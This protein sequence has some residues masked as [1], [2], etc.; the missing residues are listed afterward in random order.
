MEYSKSYLSSSQRFGIFFIA[1]SAILAAPLSI[2]A[3]LTGDSVALLLIDNVVRIDATLKDGTRTQG[4]GFVVGERGGHLYIVTANHVV[5]SRGPEDLSG[6]V[7]LKYHYAPN[8]RFDAILLEKSDGVHD[9]AVLKAEFPEN[10]PWR[11]ESLGPQENVKRGIPVFFVGRLREWYIPADPGHINQVVDHEIKI[12]NLPVQVGTSGA[13]LIS[14]TGIIGMITR[15]E[16]A[17]VSYA[18][19]IDII[20]STVENWDYPWDLDDLHIPYGI[21][22][23]K[24]S[25]VF[26]VKGGLIAPGSVELDGDVYDTDSGFSL[27]AF[28][29]YKLSPKVC[30]G[31]FFDLDQLTSENESVNFID[32]GLMLKALIYKRTGNLTLKPGLGFGYGILP[33]VDDIGSTTYLTIKA[34]AEIVASTHRSFSWLGEIA[35]FGAPWG[36]ND[37]YDTAINGLVLIRGGILF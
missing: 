6:E 31:V 21:T 32:I 35:I 36:G 9:L 4:F 12:D 27:G 24:K 20:K 3:Q 22:M 37:L 15:D 33:S 29:D 30:G 26:G 7:T 23:R 2:E 17:D 25:T 11:R 16:S 10:I 19:S 8:V 1:V 34:S 18:L 5:R 14:E 28:L 13:P